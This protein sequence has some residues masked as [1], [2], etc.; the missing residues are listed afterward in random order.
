MADRWI[1]L[2]AR[3]AGLEVILP[4]DLDWLSVRKERTAQPQK[5]RLYSNG[6][7]THLALME[8]N[9]RLHT[10][11]DSYGQSRGIFTTKLWK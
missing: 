8:K 9:P 2:P 6:F 3:P 1:A 5:R 7:A 10:S 4:A 11:H